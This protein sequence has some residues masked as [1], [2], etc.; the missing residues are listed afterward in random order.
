MRKVTIIYCR[1]HQESERPWGGKTQPCPRIVKLINHFWTARIE[2]GW[3][4]CSE[5]VYWRSNAQI[6]RR[7]VVVIIITPTLV[8]IGMEGGNRLLSVLVK[9]C[10]K[11]KPSMQSHM[12]AALAPY[13]H[14]L[15]WNIYG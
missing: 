13:Y 15:A 6:H 2:R 1:P 12:D 8:L 4:F 3:L 5:S 9:G 11:K 7:N 10:L 14:F